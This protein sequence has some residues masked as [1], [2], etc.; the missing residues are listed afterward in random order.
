MGLA[1]SGYLLYRSACSTANA[2]RIAVGNVLGVVVLG[3]V[4]RLHGLFQGPAWSGVVGGNTLAAGNILV[5]STTAHVIIGVHD[6]RRV[7]ADRL[8]GGTAEG[9]GVEPCAPAQ[10]HNESTL[11]VG[12]GERLEGTVSDPEVERS[13]R[14]VIERARVVGG[15]QRRDRHHAADARERLGLW[16]AQ[17][18][19]EANSGRLTFEDGA[20]GTVATLSHRLT[21]TLVV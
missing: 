12:R 17:S 3:V 19:A 21:T 4:L 16:L 6:A 5:I 18:A 20:G 14:V 8:C 7:R 2:V 15:R 9:R 11:L 13:A 1:V 10:L